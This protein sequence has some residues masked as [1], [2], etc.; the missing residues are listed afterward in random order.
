MKRTA[1]LIPLLAAAVLLGGCSKP[2]EHYGLSV[3]PPSGFET[4]DGTENPKYVLSGKDGDCSIVILKGANTD[5]YTPEDYAA[6]S[7]EMFKRI[8]GVTV[9]EKTQLLE[10]AGCPT[11]LLRITVERTP[12][13]TTA[14]SESETAETSESSEDEPSEAS[15][16]TVGEK[17]PV[18]EQWLSLYIFDGS[19]VIN[20]RTAAP[21]SAAEAYEKKYMTMF[22]KISKAEAEETTA[23]PYESI[24][25]NALPELETQ[26]KLTDAPDGIEHAIASSV[27][28]SIADEATEA[29]TSAAEAQRI[30][31]EGGTE[32]SAP[33]DNDE[34]IRLG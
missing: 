4:V 6:K 21:L 27:R 8:E 19:D 7:A 14:A 18:S 5:G 9:D 24:T 20:I 15:E 34:I 11:S 31:L 28:Q 23:D 29:Q 17:V 22:E 12:A 30:E 25:G 26:A 10:V 16:T 1:L 2:A 33:S 13:E 3:T 32:T